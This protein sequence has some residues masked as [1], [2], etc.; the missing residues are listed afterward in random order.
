[1]AINIE[2]DA[3]RLKLF[4]GLLPE[5]MVAGMRVALAIG[6]GIIGTS[7]IDKLNEIEI[8]KHKVSSNYLDTKVQQAFIKFTEASTELHSFVQENVELTKTPAG[9][10]EYVLKPKLRYGKG[11]KNLVAWEKIQQKFFSLVEVFQERYRQ[12]LEVG[13]QQLAR[14]SQPQQK[15][16][17]RTSRGKKT[18]DEENV[19]YLDQSGNLYRKPKVR[20]CYP[21]SQSR[22][23]LKIVQYLMNNPDFQPTDVITRAV[24]EKSSKITRDEIGKIRLGLKTFLKLDGTSIIEGKK[25]SG[26]RLSPDWHI[27]EV[28]S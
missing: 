20:Y 14:G 24:G 11:E 27:K 6:G 19:L 7:F 10:A 18:S 9:F 15:N 5:D 16:R 28:N 23:R 21:M 22:K 25:D 3:E 1:M 17:E 2:N 8:Y 4:L 13:K 26:Y 12:F